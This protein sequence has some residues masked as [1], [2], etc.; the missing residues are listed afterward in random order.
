MKRKVTFDTYCAHDRTC[1]IGPRAACLW[2]LMTSAAMPLHKNASL[3]QKLSALVGVLLLILVVVG[4]TAITQLRSVS[5]AQR[6]MY[7]DTVVPLRKVVDGGRQAAVHFRRMYPYMLK[8]DPKSREETIKLNEQSEKSVTDAIE[9]LRQGSDDAT[10][11]ETGRKLAD[12]WATYKASVTKLQASADAGNIDAAMAELNTTT[13]P[14]HVAVRNLLLEAGKQQE[15][16]ASEKTQSVAASV[17]RTSLVL[18]LLI[19]LGTLVGAALGWRLIR[20]VLGQLGG[21]PAQAVAIARQIAGGD[22]RESFQAKPGDSSS[23]LYQLAAMRG[24]LERVIGQVRDSAEAVSQASAE[25]SLGTNDLS[26]RT[27]QQAAALEET[28]ASMESLG[29]SSRQ[30]ADSAR[31]A[32]RLAQTA[33]SVA[34]QGGDVVAEV[35]KTMSGINESS[36]KIGD[37]IG[38]IDSIAFQT[39]ILA[40]NAAVEAARA[41]E[42]G[43]GFAVVAS[44]VRSLA[45]RSADAAKEIKGLIGTS[46]A[47]VEQGT[48]LVDRA[49]STMAEVVSAIQ[50]VTDLVG[51][52]SAASSAQNEGVSQVGEAVTL[53]D[54]STQQNAALVEESAA[55]AQSMRQQAAQL[56]QAV[57]AFRIGDNAAH[58][59]ALPG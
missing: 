50:R 42:Q 56:V 16:E 25:I 9:F 11:R 58:R 41:G 45:G 31:E 52:I 18:S 47:R 21:D 59:R 44:E 5:A 17:D 7:T 12:A 22:L 34:V 10:L 28:A 55:A 29:T 39:N 30:N 6:E 57:D 48:Q 23:L 14:L 3:A 20:S 1:G 19:G 32:N 26:A 33:S 8:A 36:R 4:V 40:L 51:E 2:R 53:M 54:Q 13:D 35:V 46:V 15:K 38:V 27:E 24:Q 43:R 49:G 37:I